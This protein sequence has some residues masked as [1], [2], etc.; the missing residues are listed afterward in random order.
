LGPHSNYFAFRFS[1][2]LGQP[3]IS[4]DGLQFYRSAIRHAFGSGAT[5]GIINKTYSATQLNVAEASRR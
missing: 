3:E 2:L 4:T 1:R 5:H